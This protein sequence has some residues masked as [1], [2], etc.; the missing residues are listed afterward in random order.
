M[1]LRLITTLLAA[2]VL[3]VA[4]CSSG[5]SQDSLPPPTEAAAPTPTAAACTAF[6]ESVGG[7]TVAR[8][9]GGAPEITIAAG[10][11]QASELTVVDLCPGS[12]P[13]A[14][15]ASIITVDYVGVTLSTGEEFDSTFGQQPATF[16]LGR[17]IPGWQQGLEGMQA[18][19]S[20][21]LIIPAELAYGDAGADAGG[22]SGT[23]VFVVDLLAI[24]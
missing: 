10:A 5:S 24:T 15:A 4:A 21:L 1:R 3:P 23:L 14:D 7:V 19:S 13:G 20:R 6:S 18:G 2:L 11:E 22:P 17:L 16:P 8:T 12:G 9:G